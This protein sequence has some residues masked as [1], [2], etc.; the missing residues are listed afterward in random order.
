M[1]QGPAGRGVCWGVRVLVGTWGL[2]G[3]TA[4][5][6]QISSFTH[7]LISDLPGLSDLHGLLLL[8]SR[9]FVH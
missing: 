5:N 4:W 9:D 7:W 3:L 6:G 2:V 1:G 8:R